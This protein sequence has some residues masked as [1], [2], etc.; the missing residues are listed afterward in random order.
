MKDDTDRPESADQ[1]GRYFQYNGST[2]DDG[3][4]WYWQQHFRFWTVDNQPMRNWRNHAD[5]YIER[6]NEKEKV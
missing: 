1:A 5:N 4:S 6:L 3:T 2:Y